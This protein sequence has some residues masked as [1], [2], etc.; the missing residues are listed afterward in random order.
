M[1]TN[2]VI[3]V[4]SDCNL[5]CKWCDQEHTMRQNAGYQMSMSEVNYIVDSCINRGLRFDIIE[6]TGGEVTLWNNIKKGAE[7]FRTI[8]D[9]LTLVSN[10]N[11]PELILSLNLP[12]WVVSASQ[13]TK[14]QLSVYKNSDR[15]DSICYNEHQHKKLTEIPIPGSVPAQCNVRTTPKL[16]PQNLIA[17]IRGSVYY[18]CNT[19]QISKKL[20]LTDDLVC[21][22]DDDFMTKYSDK[23]YDKA[24]CAYCHCN[25]KVWEVL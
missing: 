9:E 13:A 25:G 11:N 14:E 22:F 20:P 3:W 24:Q 23:K 12:W 16:I 10:G 4:T 2:L 8:C 15:T 19:Y 5:T 6:I 21:S 17:Y 1:K 7:A 18:C